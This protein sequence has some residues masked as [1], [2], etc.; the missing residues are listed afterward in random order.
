MQPGKKAVT[1][2]TTPVKPDE[3]LLDDYR[4]VIE[5]QK[6]SLPSKG[7]KLSKMEEKTDLEWITTIN[8]AKEVIKYRKI[9]LSSFLNVKFNILIVFYF[10]FKVV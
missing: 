7:F 4:G 5:K 6:N 10:L 2:D 8:K 3:R 1:G 9:Y